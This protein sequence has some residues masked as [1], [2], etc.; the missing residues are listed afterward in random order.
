MILTRTPSERRAERYA[1]GPVHEG[2]KRDSFL[3]TEVLS[4]LRERGK[5]NGREADK[6]WEKV[7]GTATGGVWKSRVP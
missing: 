3:L 4:L 6:T 7:P 5:K 1:R 2:E